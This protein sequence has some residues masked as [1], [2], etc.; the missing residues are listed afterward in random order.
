MQTFSTYGSETIIRLFVGDVVRQTDAIAE[1]ETV[2]WSY[3]GE[4]VAEE[5][6]RDFVYDVGQCR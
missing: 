6:L 4:L 5:R 1:V 2:I 3:V